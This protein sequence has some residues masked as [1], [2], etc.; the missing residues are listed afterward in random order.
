MM[1]QFP[2]FIAP[3]AAAPKQKKAKVAS[4]YAVFSPPAS[5]FVEHPAPQAILTP[6]DLIAAPDFKAHWRE[7]MTDD[8]YHADKTA[9]G[10]SS[11]RLLPDSPKAFYW[12]VFKQIEKKKSDALRLGTLIH[13]AVLEGAKFRERYHLMPEFMGYTKDGKLSAQSG[14]ARDKKT[15]WLN[16]LPPGAVVTTQA[17]LDMILGIIDGIFEHPQ[18][19][20]L[21]KDGRPETPGYYRDEETGIRLKIKPDFVSFDGVRLNDLKSAMSVRGRKFGSQSFEKRYDIQMFMQAEGIRQITGKFPEVVS[22]IGVEKEPPYECG[23]FYFVKED[24]L[25]AES[26]YRLALRALKK[27]IDSNKWPQRQTQIERIHTPAWFINAAVNG[28]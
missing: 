11:L 2:D 10:S 19:P 9:V 25:Q 1:D 22:L 4:A 24:F 7:D 14:E 17:E 28:E 21:M 15:A 23:I 12:R 5:A 16:D 20:D 6:R 8:E 26:D 18:G 3:P 13:L 27:C